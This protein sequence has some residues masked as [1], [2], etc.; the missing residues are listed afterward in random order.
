MRTIPLSLRHTCTLYQSITELP[1]A[2]RVEFNCYLMQQTGIGTDV[3]SV[4]RHFESVMGFL[5]ADQKAEAIDALV[6]LMYNVQFALE[7]FSPQSLAFGCL[8]ASVDGVPTNDLTEEGLTA[9]RDR[10][11]GYGLT[12]GMVDEEVAAVKKNFKMSSLSTFLRAS[13][14]VPTS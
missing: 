9:L 10:L 5:G 12:A 4:Q 6:L 14:P 11:S 13:T 8:V 2:R 3:A 7:K 1:E